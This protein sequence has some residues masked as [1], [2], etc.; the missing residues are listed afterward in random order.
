MFENLNKPEG[1]LNF[2]LCII[3]LSSSARMKPKIVTMRAI[4]LR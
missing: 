2:R 4:V 1:Y 3:R